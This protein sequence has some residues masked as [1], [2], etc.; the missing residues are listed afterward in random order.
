MTAIELKSKVTKVYDY[1]QTDIRKYIP[2]YTPDEA[3]LEKDIARV[4][5]SHGEKV[6]PDTVEEGDM[7]TLSLESE[8][9]KYNKSGLV[10]MVGKGL[11]SR[12]LEK[13]LIGLEKSVPF[14]VTADGK[15][16]RGT[17]E[18]IRRTIIPELTDENVAAFGMDGI[19]TVEDLKSYCVDRQLDRML[20]DSEDME[21]ASAVLWQNLSENSEFVLD[22]GEVARAM[23]LAEAK[24]VDLESQKP[25]FETKEEEE[26]FHKEFEEEFGEPYQEMDIAAFVV[27]MYTMELKLAAMGCEKARREGSLLTEDDYEEY[28]RRHMEALPGESREE[29]L[30][31][32]TVEEFAKFEYNNLICDELDDYVRESFKKAMNPYRRQEA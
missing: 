17:V 9:E 22:E 7:V 20:D 30:R 18:Q 25:V 24:R 12:E 26:A 1:K 5:K 3:Q 2:D 11:Y 29:V 6:S 15:E 4:L 16:V 14:T 28:I 27:D 13:K 23:E 21:M 32:Y 10:V 19:M 31:K 8:A